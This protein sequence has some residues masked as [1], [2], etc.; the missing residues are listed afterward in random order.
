M[1]FF[2]TGWYRRRNR[3][4]SFATNTTAYD[5]HIGKWGNLFDGRWTRSILLGQQSCSSFFVAE[6]DWR[7]IGRKHRSSFIRMFVLYF[8]LF[9]LFVLLVLFVLFVLFCFVCLFLVV[10]F[11]FSGSHLSPFFF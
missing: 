9:V 2:F 11:S 8:C 5:K 7:L 10:R 3:S 1:F 6:F 4:C